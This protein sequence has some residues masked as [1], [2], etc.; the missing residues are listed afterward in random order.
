MRGMCFFNGK[1]ISEAKA[2]Q[3]MSGLE[4]EA[5]ASSFSTTDYTRSS[6][7]HPL[8]STTPFFANLKLSDLV[9]KTVSSASAPVA[10]EP[11]SPAVASVPEDAVL[12]AIP[13]VWEQEY[14]TPILDLEAGLIKVG[15]AQ[16]AQNLFFSHHENEMQ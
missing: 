14:I 9:L 2:M 1:E 5:Y 8:S 12:G 4:K 15:T 10:A 3:V 6:P 11:S 7:M 16:W 13:T